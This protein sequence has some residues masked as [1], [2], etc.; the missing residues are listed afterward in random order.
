MLPAAPARLVAEV[1]H[2]EV[3]TDRGSTDCA[4]GSQRPGIDPFSY[5]QIAHAM[6]SLKTSG[7][8]GMALA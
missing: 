5:A 6:P 4:M 7:V 2:L 1:A 3:A 8:A